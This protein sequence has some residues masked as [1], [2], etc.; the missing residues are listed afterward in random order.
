MSDIANNTRIAKNTLLL[1]FRMLFSMVVAL[2]TSRVVLNTLGVED[3]GIYN[4]VG[5]IVSMLSFFN[6]SM[7]TSTQRFLNYEMGRNNDKGLRSVFINAVNAHYLIGIVTVIGL[8]TVG[9]WF[10]YNKLNIPVEQFDAAV[11]VYHCSVLSLFVSIISTPYNAAIIANE[12]MGVYAYYS[13]IEVVLKLL[14]VY[15]LV[16]IPYNKL[17]VYGLLSLGVSLLMRILYNVYCIR[18]FTECKYQWKWNVQLMKKMFFFSGWMLFGCISDMLSKQGVNVLINIFFGPVFN[19]A[20]AIAV[21]VQAAINNFVINFMTAVRPQIIKSYSAGE[22]L[23]MYRLVFSSSKLSFYLLFVLTTPVLIYTDFILQWWLK[24]VPEYCVLFTRLVLIELLISSAYV[25]IAQ[26]N[27]AS[28]KIRNYQM[29]IAI[30]FLA[31][32]V[33]TYVLYEMK[34]PVYST[35]VLSV[36]LAVVGLFVRVLILRRDNDFPARTYL[37]KI[38]LPLLP[39]SALSLVV[40]IS[41]YNFVGTSFLTFIANSAVG[42]LTSIVLIWKFGLDKTEKGFITEKILSRIKKNK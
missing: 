3:F 25:P 9:L 22:Y 39:V 21:Q 42:F 10:V 35:F 24:Q 38:M 27:Q 16:V 32:F 41:I 11:W 26:I 37:V 13:I 5:G 31:T 30:I 14:I 17:V 36:V 19:A 7:A 28:G 29:A 18:N 34:M 15:L 2:Y 23:H 33:L 1:Y 20:R 12:Q 8:E 6:S 4:V 40:P